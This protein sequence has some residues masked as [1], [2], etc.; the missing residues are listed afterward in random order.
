MMRLL[1]MKPYAIGL[2]LL[3]GIGCANAQTDPTAQGEP[4]RA[5]FLIDGRFFTEHPEPLPTGAIS[6]GVLKDSLDGKLSVVAFPAGLH[7]SAE[8][9]A[10]ALPVDRVFCGRGL[11]QAAG[12]ARLFPVSIAPPAP[13]HCAVGDAL[14]AFSE[15]D[16]TG[17]TWSGRDLAG[18]PVVLNFWHTGCGPCIGEMPELNRWIEACPEALFLAV[19]WNTAEEIRP[20]VERRRFAFHRIVSA[21][22]LWD[23]LGVSQTPVTMVVDRKGIIRRIEIGTSILQ[24]RRLLACLKEV[25]TE[26]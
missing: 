14:P 1:K 3:L 4:I 13:L 26:K 19:T 8:A 6:M 22:R 20:I 16:D 18:R 7:L 10:L 12:Q 21:R 15:V 17:R 23:A 11:L 9:A 25:E 2:G 5:R 24:R